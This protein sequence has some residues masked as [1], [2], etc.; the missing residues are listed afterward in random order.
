MA[1]ITSYPLSDAVMLRCF[2]DDHFKT[3][4]IS[5]NMMVPIDKIHAAKYGMLP[6][7]VSR[8]CTSFPDYTLL[9]QKLASLYG[10]YLDS[11]VNKIGRYQV[12][13]ISIGGIA[14]KYAFDGEDMIKELSDLLFAILLSPLRDADGLF[15]EEGF[16]QEKRQILEIFDSEYN[17]KMIYASL[18]GQQILFGD[19]PEGIGRYGQ[20]EE[21]AALERAEVSAAWNELLQEAR[22]EVF[23]L[24]NCEVQL[25]LFEKTFQTLGKSFAIEPSAGIPAADQKEVREEMQLSQSK[26][27]L[28]FRTNM[29]PE[30][31]RIYGLMSAVLGGTPSSKLFLNVREKLSLCYFCSSRMDVNNRTMYIVSGVEEENI[32]LAKEAILQQLEDMKAG[33]I[34]EEEIQSAKLAMINSYQ[35]VND[36]L[37]SVEFWYLTQIFS[38]IIQTPEEA[39]S[40]VMAVTKEQL[41]AAAAD[42]KL[43]TIYMLVGQS[44]AKGANDR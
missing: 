30:E 17:D 42:L 35:G 14:T 33:K 41:I 6:S 25:E 23:V 24:G 21:V 27:F 36:S 8:A 39:V 37:G 19:L 10:A 26:L 4:R 31:K 7:L 43:D 22:F 3:M 29:E 44:E 11:S 20:K 1:N 13:T 15:P 28:G 38:G 34:T 16:E 9:G 2:T 40:E 18:R 12:L 5:V 32:Q